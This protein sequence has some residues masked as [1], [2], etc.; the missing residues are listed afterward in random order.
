M[1]CATLSY[2]EREDIEVWDYS[3]VTLICF[4][5]GIISFSLY[6]PIA[7]MFA[8]TLNNQN[9]ITFSISQFYKS[10]KLIKVLP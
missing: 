8:K 2:E 9:F 1:Q 5:N 7:E 10:K 4:V 6:L 3:K